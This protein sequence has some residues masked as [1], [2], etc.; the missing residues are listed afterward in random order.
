MPDQ[1]LNPQDPALL[2]NKLMLET[3]QIP[4]RELESFHARGVVV[5][6]DASLDLVEVGFELTQDNKAQFQA[7]LDANSVGPVADQTAQAWHDDNTPVWA[8][9]IAPWVLVQQRPGD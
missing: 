8:L 3:A 7:W 6:V 1:A 4:W 5:R 2:K 9:V